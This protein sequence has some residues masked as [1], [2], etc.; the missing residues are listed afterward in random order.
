MR[1]PGG[2]KIGIIRFEY[3]MFFS[4]KHFY[5]T[6]YDDAAL[7]K[8]MFVS[9]MIPGLNSSNCKAAK[10]QKAISPSFGWVSSFPLSSCPASP[11]LT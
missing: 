6:F 1:L 10:F 9:G 8:G 11:L 7:L 3:L 2:Y 5:L 4:H